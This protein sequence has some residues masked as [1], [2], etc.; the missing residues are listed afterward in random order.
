TWIP[1][2]TA[3]NAIAEIGSQ[4][5]T[6]R[7]GIAH[8]INPLEYTWKIIYNAL[9]SYGIEFEVVPVQE[10][11]YQLK[12]NPE[13]QNVDV[14]PLATLTDFFDNIFLS[15]HGVTLETELTKKFS[16]SITNCPALESNLMMKYLKFWNSQKFI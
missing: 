12:T 14:N 7:N 6:S 16:P 10:F 2:N 5:Q 13:F 11:I 8:I 9:E 4:D 3:A 1:A 15:G